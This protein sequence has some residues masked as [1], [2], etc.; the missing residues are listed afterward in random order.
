MTNESY[1][2]KIIKTIEQGS[3]PFIT[4]VD[5]NQNTLYIYTICFHYITNLGYELFFTFNENIQE[6][7]MNFIDLVY[8][9]NLEI[10]CDTIIQDNQTALQNYVKKINMDIFLNSKS[11][12]PF[13]EFNL[14]NYPKMPHVSDEDISREHIENLILKDTKEL[15]LI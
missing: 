12:L 7:S 4:A 2:Q 14:E 5:E 11:L 10:N 15:R 3:F 6:K 8:Q 9:N 13:F 1:R